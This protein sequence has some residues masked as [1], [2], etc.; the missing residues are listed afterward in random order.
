MNLWITDILCT[1][2][3]CIYDKNISGDHT[4]DNVAVPWLNVKQYAQEGD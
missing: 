3:Q 2:I 1:V 4:G